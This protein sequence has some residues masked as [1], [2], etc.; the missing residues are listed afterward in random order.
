MKSP[1]K[2]PGANILQWEFNGTAFKQIGSGEPSKTTSW[3]SRNGFMEYKFLDGSTWL[4]EQPALEAGP[5]QDDAIPLFPKKR[6]AAL[7]PA[8]KKP[9][10]KQVTEQMQQWKL[11]HSQVYHAA[12]KKF[13]QKAAAN[14]ERVDKCTLSAHVAAKTAEAKKRIFKT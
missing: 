1:Q 3:I 8:T 13:K 14:G 11:L 6:P 10:G 7:K 4:S 2:E 5:P 12:V 9:A